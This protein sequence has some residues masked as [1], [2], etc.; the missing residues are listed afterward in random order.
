MQIVVVGCGRMGSGVA[1]TLQVRDHGV[2]VVDKDPNAFAALGEQ[3][4]GRTVTGNAL[5]KDL[6]LRAGINRAD[7]LASVTDSDEIDL[8]KGCAFNRYRCSSHA[9]RSG[10]VATVRRRYAAPPV[11]TAGSSV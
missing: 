1:R 11:G 4:T 2:T 5:D 9:F 7:G 3:F 8:V 6:L 10:L